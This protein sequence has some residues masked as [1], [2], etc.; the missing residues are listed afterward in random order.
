MN[1]WRNF[2][3]V[4]SKGQSQIDC[5]WLLKLIELHLIYIELNKGNLNSPDK[6]SPSNSKKKKINGRLSKAS[7]MF[8]LLYFFDQDIES[9]ESIALQQSK[10]LY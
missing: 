3:L 4:P 1:R 6:L 8:E 2:S 5:N 7:A 9:S 10:C